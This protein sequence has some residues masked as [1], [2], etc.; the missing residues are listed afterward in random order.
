MHRFISELLILFH[1][2]ISLS[3]CQYHGVLMTVALQYILKAGRLI[4]PISFSLSRLL[5]LFRVF[6]V[7]LLIVKLFVLVLWKI[8]REFGSL[9]GAVLNL[10]L[11]WIVYSFSV[12]YSFQSKSTMYFFNY[13]CHLWFLLS[14][15]YSFMYTGLLLL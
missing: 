7:S 2:S 13:F 6:C 14:V 3:L 11:L 5:W 1:W 10:R 4:P 12:Y 15:F 8:H 9:I